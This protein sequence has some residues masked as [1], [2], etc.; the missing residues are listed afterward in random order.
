MIQTPKQESE[1]LV[2]KYGKKQ[3][4]IIA[5]TNVAMLDDKQAEQWGEIYKYLIGIK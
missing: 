4:L 5:K 2:E 3:A 1:A